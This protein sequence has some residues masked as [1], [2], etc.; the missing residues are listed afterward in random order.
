[1]IE[2]KKGWLPEGYIQTGDLFH[3]KH[4]KALLKAGFALSDYKV[5]DGP[6]VIRV[7]RREDLKDSIQ[8]YEDTQ[9]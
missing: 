6:K 3:T 2:T 9:R 7:T 5:I 1:M 8:Q 4:R